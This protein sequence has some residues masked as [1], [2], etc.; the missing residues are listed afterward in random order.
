MRASEG[1]TALPGSP[2]SAA[3][4]Q[5]PTTSWSPLCPHSVKR[6]YPKP[7]AALFSMILNYS[8]LALQPVGKFIL[9]GGDPYSESSAVPWSTTVQPITKAKGVWGG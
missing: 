3:P 8:T 7:V 4:A 1:H 5:H 2:A 6:C 9:Y